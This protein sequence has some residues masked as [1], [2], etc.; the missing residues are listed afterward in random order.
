MKRLAF[1]CK[2]SF[3]GLLAK[4]R[5]LQQRALEVTTELASHRRNAGKRRRR[6]DGVGSHAVHHV[7][8]CF[9]ESAANFVDY[10]PGALPAMFQGPLV[11]YV[12]MVLVLAALDSQV[13]MAFALGIGRPRHRAASSLR[14]D[15][16]YCDNVRA[17]IE[18]VYICS[19][20]QVIVSMFDDPAHYGTFSQHRKAAWYVVEH[21]LFWRVVH[22]NC[23]LG[24][25]PGAVL[26][27]LQAIAFIP[28]AAPS[29]VRDSLATWFAASDRTA[30]SWLARWRQRW[31]GH[32]DRIDVGHDMEGPD[33]LLKEAWLHAALFC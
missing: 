1:G 8:T 14:K 6:L 3:E 22:Q 20:Q 30:R 23:V 33:P 9:A 10:R 29:L 13:A 15:V 19:P 11:P 25:A 24:N 2:D 21:R 27:F 32:V 5:A 18:W 16:S 12:L 17:G 7:L 4:Q 28:T 31:G 26:L